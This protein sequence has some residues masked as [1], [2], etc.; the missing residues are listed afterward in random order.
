MQVSHS[1]NALLPVHTEHKTAS[2]APPAAMPGGLYPLHSLHQAAAAVNNIPKSS[3]T[4]F[5]QP[6]PD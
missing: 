1:H 4:T 6:L 3:D 5:V 2:H